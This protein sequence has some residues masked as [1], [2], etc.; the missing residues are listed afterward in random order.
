MQ[1]ELEKFQDQAGVENA[2][3]PPA[4]WYTHPHFH[5]LDLKLLKQNWQFVGNTEQVQKI[6]DYF[7]GDFCGEPYLVI[8]TSES[9]IK[10]FYNVC[11][12][13]AAILVQGEGC[14]KELT[15]P[16][17][18]WN[19]SIEGKLIKAP[20]I[21]GIQNFDR[22][23]MSLKEIPIKVW[24]KFVLLNFSG[25]LKDIDP[26]W[27]MFADML[28]AA[29]TDK[30]KFVGRR[31]YIQKCNWKVYV[32]NY[33]DGGY[34]VNHLHKGL[35][36]QLDMDAYTVENFK[37]WTLQ[38]CPGNTNPPKQESLD[39]RERIGNKALYAWF[40]PNFMINRYGNIMDTNWVYP[41]TENSCLTI[42]DYYFLDS[43]GKEFIDA[44]IK[45]SEQ[46][47]I[48]D[49]DICESVQKGLNSVAYDVGRYAPS[50]ESGAYLFHCLVKQDYKKNL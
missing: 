3:T 38:W 21:A 12:H 19:Y 24:G 22:N 48:E 13:H 16:Y 20:H 17:H 8:R 14:A 34:H 39:F 31:S 45:A 27:Q 35:A 32:D 2:E 28:Q 30:L 11:R 4:S 43:Q 23:K 26:E 40:Y 9:E 42:F 46:V 15:C 49:V 47:Q 44:S 33:L 5:A 36:G 10:A 18:A 1:T 7:S 29:E 41:L 25:N 6:G 37:R 50:L